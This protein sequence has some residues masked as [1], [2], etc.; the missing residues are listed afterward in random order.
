LLGRNEDL[1]EIAATL[2]KMEVARVA[3]GRRS[4]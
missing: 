2:D 1:A 3:C 4:G